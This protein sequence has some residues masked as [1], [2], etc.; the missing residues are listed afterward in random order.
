MDR[1][2][3]ISKSVAAGTLAM[4][5]S[6]LISSCNGNGR[7]GLMNPH[8]YNSDAHKILYYASLAPSGHNSQ[9]WAVKILNETQWVVE[10][11]K[12]R[13]LSIV[14]SENR[15]VMLSLGAFIEN[16]VTAAAVFGFT[17]HITIIAKTNFDQQV[18]EVT[19]EKR[20]VEKYPLQRLVLRRTIKS[21]MQSR[22]LLKQDISAFE[23]EAGSN[24]YYFPKGSRHADI[25]EKEAVDNFKIQSESDKAQEELACWIRF[26]NS[27]IE[28]YRDG[29]TSYS[30]EIN[31]L[32][33]WYVRNFMDKKNVMGKSF[34]QKGIEKTIEQVKQGAG[35]IVLTSN[36]EATADLI[37]VGRKFQRMA[38][39]ARERNIAIHPMTQTIEEKHGQKNIKANH[40]PATIPQF[41]LR[42]GYLNKYPKPVTLRRPVQWFVHYCPTSIQT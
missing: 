33:G 25:M 39:I 13:N 36:S 26:K 32:A 8:I 20:E 4:G 41:M 3:F 40:K 21:N 19:L 27:A 7:S 6:V 35:W 10:A 12:E 18:A 22:Q 23:K 29:I 37:D 11:D 1:R 5:A 28:K 38:L 24:L 2:E 34:R 42:V 31:G 16:L 17:A 15:E 30:M 14:D 9:P